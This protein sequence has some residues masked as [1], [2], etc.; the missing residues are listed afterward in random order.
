MTVQ[1]QPQWQSQL[2]PQIY[3]PAMPG[4]FRSLRRVFAQAFANWQRRRAIAALQSFNDHLL[5]DIGIT[6]EQIP[7]YVREIDRR[8]AHHLTSPGQQ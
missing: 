1:T 6:R 2:Q 4:L 3:A 7:L 5:T 8:E